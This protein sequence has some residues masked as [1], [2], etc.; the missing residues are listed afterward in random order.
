MF[1]MLKMIRWDRRIIRKYRTHYENTPIKIYRK[2]SPP[3][4]ENFQIKKTLIFF[5]F[6]ARNIDC[7]YSVE[8]PRQG[9]CN[10]YTQSMFLSKNKKNNVYPC[11]PQ[12]YCI[13]VEFKGV[14][15]IWHVYVMITTDRKGRLCLIEPINEGLSTRVIFSHTCRLC[16]SA[17]IFNTLWGHSADDRRMIIFFFSRK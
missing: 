16:S 2:I 4:T 6:F 17:L 9:C 13:K 15:I 8:P 11:K 3:I 1:W 12:F 5:I 14:K 10:E 7:G